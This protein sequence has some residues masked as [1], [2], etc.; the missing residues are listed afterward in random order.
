[1][2][3]HLRS[4]TQ[5]RA[6][7]AAGRHG[8]LTRAAQELSVTQGAISRQIKIIENFLGTRLFR[9]SGRGV[10]PAERAVEYAN[11]LRICLD[12]MGL[13]TERMAANA[14]STGLQVNAMH[15][16]AMRW[17]IPRLPSFQQRNPRCDVRISTSSLP[18]EIG[19]AHV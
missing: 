10:V 8:S 15:T 16:F 3:R 5:L 2:R 6:F 12:R 11:E 18:V 7:E 14:S 17:L 19:R 1:M 9:P 4:L 13:A